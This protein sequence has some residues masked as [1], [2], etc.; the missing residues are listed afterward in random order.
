V[1]EEEFWTATRALL[2]P[3]YDERYEHCK[4][5]QKTRVRTIDIPTVDEIVQVF[6]TYVDDAAFFG[7]ALI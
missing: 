4:H 6:C 2:G 3:L 7:E 5:D 1:C